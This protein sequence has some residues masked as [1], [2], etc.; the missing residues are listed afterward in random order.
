MPKIVGYFPG[1][2]TWRKKTEEEYRTKF[3]HDFAISYL[4]N[5]ICESIKREMLCISKGGNSG[6]YATV[7][8]LFPEVS[9][10]G[11]LYF[12]NTDD[13]EEPKYACKYMKKFSI[14]SLTPGLYWAVFRNGLMHSHHPKWLRKTKGSWYISNV[15]ELEDKFGIFTQKFA[16]E[17][18]E[19]IISFRDELEV[20][21]QSGKKIKMDN[22]LKVLVKCGKLITKNDLK[23]YA[24]KDFS[25]LKKVENNP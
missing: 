8:F 23:K 7:R 14:L 3:D 19:S 25:E 13:K 11:N 18:C 2:L 10:L 22:F 5:E 17:I 20:E 6:F 12:G 16:D 15:T 24:K 21:K 4:E 1:N 9:H